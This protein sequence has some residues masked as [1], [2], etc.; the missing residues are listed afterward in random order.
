MFVVILSTVIGIVVGQAF[1][2]DCSKFTTVISTVSS[3]DYE[4]AIF[5]SGMDDVV[6]TSGV[7]PNHTFCQRNHSAARLIMVRDVAMASQA[8]VLNLGSQSNYWVGLYKTN[9]TSD[10]LS[11][12]I[13]LDGVNTTSRHIPWDST[14]PNNNGGHENYAQVSC[15]S[16][17][18][19]IVYSRP[20]QVYC[21]VACT[22]NC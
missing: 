13:W 18:Y 3:Q 10:P 22:R 9:D 12:W 16:S 11:G 1:K 17:L 14:E 2:E 21:E 19:D 20:S 4:I 15:P 6:W 7:Q 8:C 5:D